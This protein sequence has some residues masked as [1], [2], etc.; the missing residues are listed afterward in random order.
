MTDIPGSTDRRQ[1]R[2]YQIALPVELEHGTGITRDA[3]AAGVFFETDLLFSPGV[4]I[5]FSLV[6]EHADADGPLRFQCQGE[7][8]RVEQHADK[9]GVAVRLTSYRRGEGT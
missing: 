5:S 4:S 6:F 3:S 7:V 8:L 2:R 9:V 1:A